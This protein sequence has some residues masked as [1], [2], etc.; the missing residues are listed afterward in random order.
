MTSKKKIKVL[1]IMEDNALFHK[2]CCIPLHKK[3]KM[4]SLE[5]LT[6][7]PD[8]NPIEHNWVIMKHCIAKEYGYITL[9][10]EMK[11]IMQKMWDSFGNDEFN[12]LI[13]SMSECKQ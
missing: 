5:H 1:I 13:E 8:I 11:K 2:K 12:H 4:Q 6:N 7:S 3:L 10:A 9:Q